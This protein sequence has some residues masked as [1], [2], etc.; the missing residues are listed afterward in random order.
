MFDVSTVPSG[1]VTI[2][3]NV[4]AVVENAFLVQLPAL[5][6]LMATVKVSHPPGTGIWK[7]ISIPS[8]IVVP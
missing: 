8:G 7:S 3:L 6:L 2:A 4:V 1:S 5:P